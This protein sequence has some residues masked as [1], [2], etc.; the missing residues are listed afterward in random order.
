MLRV[1]PAPA[2]E[3]EAQLGTKRPTSPSFVVID[4]EKLNINTMASTV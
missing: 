4:L 2:L 1:G 3:S